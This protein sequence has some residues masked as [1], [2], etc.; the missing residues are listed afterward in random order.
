MENNTYNIYYDKEG[1]FLELTLGEPPHNEGTEELESGIFVTK[2]L[3]TNEIY[4]IGI[5]SFKKK[6]HLLNN[7]LKRL[8]VNFPLSISY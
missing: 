4:S 7:I 5:V 2:N 8:N 3:E 6:Y 1:D